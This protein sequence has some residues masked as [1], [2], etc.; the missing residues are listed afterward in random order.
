MS[1]LHDALEKISIL[2]VLIVLL[3]FLGI[4]LLLDIL[5]YHIGIQIKVFR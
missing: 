1:S 2:E 4:N 3:A 5:G